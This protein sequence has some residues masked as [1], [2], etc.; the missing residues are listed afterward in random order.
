VLAAER[1]DDGTIELVVRTPEPS[2]A[3]RELRD[4]RAAVWAALA[5]RDRLPGHAEHLLHDA[6]PDGYRPVG[7]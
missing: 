2:D 3:E 7:A 1:H 6:L 4:L 5:L